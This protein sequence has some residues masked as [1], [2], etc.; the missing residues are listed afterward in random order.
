M[1]LKPSCM[2]WTMPLI[3]WWMPRILHHVVRKPMG[4]K[5][6]APA[7]QHESPGGCWCDGAAGAVKEQRPH[8]SRVRTG[9]TQ[10]HLGLWEETSNGRRAGGRRRRG[11]ARCQEY[12]HRNPRSPACTRAV[13]TRARR[14]MGRTASPR[15]IV[16]ERHLWR[17]SR[18]LSGGLPRHLARA[19]ENRCDGQGAGG[20]PPS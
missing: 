15:R 16:D 12:Q 4:R 10:T 6:K 5:A 17:I 1:S 20:R 7:S 19:A 11:D 2:G 8:V 3:S 18:R 9:A 14:E 13:I